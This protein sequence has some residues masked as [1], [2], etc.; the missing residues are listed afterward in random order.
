[1]DRDLGSRYLLFEILGPSLSR[2]LLQLEISNLAGRLATGGPNEKCKIRSKGVM[3]WSRD[4]L[5][6]IL[7][8][9]PY[10]G[11]GSLE[12]SNLTCRLATWRPERNNAKLGQ[13][14]S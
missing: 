12:T 7:G 11:N 4:L 10:L 6:E 8:V 9:P 14:V 5:Y 13:K 2:E 1:M 3:E